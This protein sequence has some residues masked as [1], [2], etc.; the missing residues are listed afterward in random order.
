MSRDLRVLER[1]FRHWRE[2]GLVAADQEAALR[3]ASAELDRGRASSVLYVALGG[4][5][6]GLL[7]AG[8]V[9]VVAENWGAIP[10]LVKL[11]G[12]AVIQCALLYLARDF[13]E[14]FK[15]RAFLSE[16]LAFVAGGWVL[17]GIALVSQIYHLDSRPPNGVWLWL[18]LILP[19]A[20][21]LPWRA[22]AAVVL[23]AL[24]AA[25][26]LEVAASDSWLH[27]PR[28]E[29]PWLFLA[30][31]MLSAALVS[32]LPTPV[33]GLRGWVGA[34]VF[35]VGTVWLL[36]FGAAQELDHTTLDG[37][38]LLVAAAFLTALVQPSRC[39]PPVWDGLTARAV[40]VAAVLPW[41]VI[42]AEYD[43][44]SVIDMLAVGLA[45]LLQVGVAVLAIRAG[46]RGGSTA[47]VNLGYLAL[48]AGILTRYFDFFGEYLEGGLALVATG[49]L[50]LFVLYAME[51]ARRRTLAQGRAA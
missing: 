2:K 14:R 30:I 11:G 19:L 44:G 18:A 37:G 25:L 3:E 16:P 31:P 43:A 40:L 34:W 33:G 35:G 50:V 23:V 1:H 21:A 20:W 48:V 9:L 27:A 39:L 6:G 49:A 13:A 38:W 22:T 24:T 41:V 4:L 28:A 32:W 8:L 36:V 15:G 10:R 42:G 5:G 7:L 45:W 26:G 51:R 46:A 12:W 29:G 17:G 47:W